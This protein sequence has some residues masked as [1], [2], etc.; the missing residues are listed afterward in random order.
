MLIKAWIIAQKSSPLFEEK[1]PLTFSQIKICGLHSEI[2]L[3]ASP[4]RE[5][6]LP[7]S[8]RLDPEA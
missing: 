4:I 8:P 7:L 2:S 1:V 5:L 6:L 3:I